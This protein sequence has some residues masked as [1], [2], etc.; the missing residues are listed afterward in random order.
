MNERPKLGSE[1]GSLNVHLWVSLAG[2]VM[3]QGSVLADLGELL[4]VS[5]LVKRRPIALD[6][7]DV[8]AGPV[9]EFADWIG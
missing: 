5:R 1:Q 8:C 3:P 9:S 4:A 7:R 2:C 6:F